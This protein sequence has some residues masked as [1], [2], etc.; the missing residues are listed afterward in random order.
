[1][2]N[3]ELMAQRNELTDRLSSVDHQIRFL[4]LIKGAGIVTVAVGVCVGLGLLAD[5]V[6]D[7]PI[8]VR[9]SLLGLSA[10]VAA[11]F[12]WRQLIRPAVRSARTEELAALLESRH[13]ELQERLTS[14]VELSNPDAPD[15]YRGSLLM[16]ELLLKQARESVRD[17]PVRDAEKPINVGRWGFSGAAVLLGLLAPFLFFG[18]YGLLVARFFAPWENLERASNLYFV[19]DEGD[20]TIARGS[21]VEIAAA[22][23]WRYFES[24]LPDEVWLRWKNDRGDR[25]RRQ[26]AWNDER[27]RYVAML[28]HV[29]HSFDFEVVSGS[30]R[31]RAYHVNVVEAPALVALMLSVDP[32][33]YTGRHAELIDGAVGEMVVLEGSRLS[34][35]MAFNKPVVNAVFA[36]TPA[37]T[38]EVPAPETIETQLDLAADGMSGAL[39]LD[40]GA[41]GEFA[42]LLTDRDGLSNPDE[43]IRR[44]RVIVDEPPLVAY[45]DSEGET[46]ARPN[47]VLRLPLTASDDLGVAALELHYEVLRTGGDDGR[48]PLTG[49]LETDAALLG[50]RSVE[51]EFSLDLSELDL[52][53]GGL[54]AIRGRAADE[55]PVPGPNESWTEQRLIGISD[56]ADPYGAAELAEQQR[57]VKE[58]LGELRQAVLENQE[59]V[60]ELHAEA[61]QN[62]QDNASF[63]R[64]AEASRL[65]QDQREL[66]D[67]SEQLA[68]IFELHPLYANLGERTRAVAREPLTSAVEEMERAAG[69]ELSEKEEGFQ[70][71]SQNLAE[72]AERLERLEAE[73]EQLAAL[74]RDLLDLQQLADRTERLASDVEDFDAARSETR[75]EETAE[76]QQAREQRLATEQQQ[77]QQDHQELTAD[78]DDLL[79]RRPELLDAALEDQLERLSELAERAGEIA[80]RE[81]ALSEALQDEA[82]HNAEELAPLAERQQELIDQAEQLASD[83]G[84][85][86]QN[87]ADPLNIDALRDALEELNA[88]NT[89]EAAE[90]QQAAAD[91]LE[92]LADELARNAELSGDPQQAARQLAERQSELND[93]MRDS[94]TEPEAGRPEDAPEPT[95]ADELAAAQAAIQAAAAQL[96]TPRSADPQREEAVEASREAVEALRQDEP[97]DEAV[98]AGERTEEALARL[99]EQFG[100][101][102]ERHAEALE[103]VERLQQEQEQL[104]GQASEAAARQSEEPAESAERSEQLAAQQRQLAEELEGLDAPGAE[105]EQQRAAA[106]ARAAEGD[107]NADQLQDAPASQQEARQALA[108]LEQA[109][110]GEPSAAEAVAG[111]QE[112]QQQIA[113]GAEGAGDERDSD[114]LAEQAG[115]QED[116]AE[117]LARLQT[118]AAEEQRAAAESAAAE[119]AEALQSAANDAGQAEEAMQSVGAAQESLD[120]L[121]EALA[122]TAGENPQTANAAAE[123]GSPAGDQQGSASELADAA[124]DLAEEQRNLASQ[125]AEQSGQTG[126]DEG[127]AENDSTVPAAAQEQSE[128]AR[129]A[130]EMAVETARQ[131]GAESTAAEQAREFAEQAAAAAEQAA[132][133]QLAAAAESAQQAGESAES[134][135]ESLANPSQGE[136]DAQPEL[137]RQAEQLAERQRQAAENLTS[138][139]NSTEARRTAQQQGQ[140]QLEQAA[141]QLTSEFQDVFEQLSSAPLSEQDRAQQASESQASSSEAQESMRAAANQQ[142]RGDF[143]SAAEAAQSAAEA[144]RQ[145]AGQA[146][147]AAQQPADAEDSPVPGEAGSQ[148]AQAS[149]QLEAAGQQLNQPLEMSPEP[150]Q[151]A[152][153]EEATTDDSASRGAPEGSPDD[154]QTAEADTGGMQP[155]EQQGD[156]ASASQSLQDAADAL[157]Q[158]VARLQPSSPSNQRQ[159]SS[160]SSQS[161]SE[162]PSSSRS[163]PQDSERAGTGTQEGVSLVDLELQLKELSTRDWGELPGTLQTEL[164]SSTRRRP[165][166]DYARLIK[167]YFDEISRRQTPELDDEGN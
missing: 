22:A 39:S 113:R 7:F 23:E 51:T 54:V 159:Q 60:D 49:V 167:L 87:P 127:L 165:Q 111:L 34:L 36:W 92:R 56:A 83:N 158:A 156:D 110:R 80:D 119:A 100:S 72:A 65:E 15:E 76:Q 104:A 144:L 116:V 137:S 31:T 35:S 133:G 11:F 28:P 32:P 47:D 163:T 18:G 85:E 26:M 86:I 33:A 5:F 62:L 103:Q 97:G 75:P 123:E 10:V 57:Q 3:A 132:S 101:L 88:G 115:A 1:M 149:R 27:G 67:R 53:D 112:E 131:T 143:Q 136:G 91:A 151:S 155:G 20:R 24:S 73:F 154:A 45:A 106:Q 118:P 94:L 38:D 61:E 89:D 139:A 117:E 146:R 134:S 122:P 55:R 46:E 4:G 157:Q 68:A 84:P 130:A 108:D 8:A 90:R 71:A 105:A 126:S 79:E 147:T 74:E 81:E 50:G 21:D 107:L 41:G 152:S 43:P 148:V 114:A 142:Q 96:Q 13:P 129:E 102:E 70:Q 95:G 161:P 125:T 141:E 124:A 128:L 138:A 12:T 93:E 140:R 135:A 9:S 29:F 64:D 2:S 19:V 99:A 59:Q 44:I 16:R 58:A 14:A 160:A 63:E 77:L 153:T 120:R 40:A 145:A 82:A 162:M 109:L 6:W 30:A 48:L 37:S 25:D 69:G 150:T 17:V 42:I 164:Q 98:A 66:V 78:L 121:A 52:S 166:G